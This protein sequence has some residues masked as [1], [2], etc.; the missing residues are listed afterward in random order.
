MLYSPEYFLVELGLETRGDLYALRSF[1][2]RKEKQTKSKDAEERKQSLIDKIRCKKVKHSSGPESQKKN[3]PSSSYGK[4]RKFELGWQHFSEVQKRF[5]AVRQSRG[6]G[7]RSVSM[8]GNS[9]IS[10]ILEEAR[11]LFFPQGKS[12]YGNWMDMD[13]ELA[14]FKGEV[15]TSLTSHEGNV[16]DF[17]LQSYF[18]LHKLT[19]VRLYLRTRQRGTSSISVEEGEPEAES[20]T[21]GVLKGSS[22]ERAKLREE[23]DGEYAESLRADRA[24]TERREQALKE[25]LNKARKVEEIH[26]A[27]LSRVLDEPTVDEPRVVV[28]VRHIDLGL[29]NRAFKPNQKMAAVYDWIGSLQLIPLYFSLSS[30]PGNVIDPSVSID[31]SADKVLFMEQRDDP[32]PLSADDDEVS[33]KGFGEIGLE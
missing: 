13:C 5:V 11:N 17:S 26:A 16:M 27:R 8:S 31:C 21:L 20:E 1:C 30:T 28:R 24:K 4:P 23:Q 19:R 22:R 10:D 12:V 7:T 25:E 15:K 14:N 9:T 29:V 3:T 33:F 6:G 32:I 18:E 2:E